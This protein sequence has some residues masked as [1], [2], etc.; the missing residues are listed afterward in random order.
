MPE[1]AAPE[2]TPRVIEP[3]RP[4]DA[5]TRRA[6]LERLDALAKPLGSLGRLEDL[7]SWIAACQQACP[8]RPLD[9]VRAVVLAGD[10]GVAA[11]G[12]SAY[13]QNVTAAMV[14]TF[15]AGRAAAA[16][17]AREHGVDL[18]IFDLGVDD[19]LGDLPEPVGRFK[20]RRASRPLHL[21]DALTPAEAEQA[22]AAGTVI[23]TGQL[24]AGADLIIIGDLGIGNTTPAACLIAAALGAPAEAVTGTGTGLDP[25]ALQQKTAIVDQ[26]LTRMGDRARDPWQRLTGLGSADLVAGVAIMITAAR[27]GV[28]I[29][30]DGLISVAEAVT[31][32][33]LAPGVIDWCAAGHRST[34]PGQR[35]ACEKYGL[36]PIL[37]AGMRLGEGSGALV[38]LPVLRSAVTLL[39]EMAL[40]SDL[41]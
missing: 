23:A 41:A 14:R 13:P 18:Q 9:R 36:A 12:V 1:Q 10:H 31:A 21:E 24:Q 11:H 33:Q 16:V 4:P 34:E 2:S 39:R 20:V 38:A 6:A 27:A 22:Y 8:P 30:L 17:L 32:E 26:A 5:I 3:I 29:L 19:D 15:A 25:A 35:L 40:L 7:A 28:P 37:D